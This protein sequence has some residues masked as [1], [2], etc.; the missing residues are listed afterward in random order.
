MALFDCGG[1]DTAIGLSESLAL[2]LLFVN[3]V[4]NLPL[5]SMLRLLAI[6]P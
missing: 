4:T 1:L 2:L 5:N 6:L 3:F